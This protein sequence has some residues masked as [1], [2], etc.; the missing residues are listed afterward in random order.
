MALKF[1]YKKG[2]N[3]RQTVDIMGIP[4]DSVT[5]QDAL[6]R[7]KTFLNTDSVHTIYTPNAEIMMDA[8]RDPYLKN[9]L[10]EADMII[11]D[12]AGVV[13]ASRILGT[14]LPSKV[15]GFDLLKNTLGLRLN[16][17]TRFY[18][19]GGAPGVAEEAAINILGKYQ[20]VEIAGYR[21]GYF[22]AEEEAKIIE[23]INASNADVLAVALGAPKQE[24]WI[25]A[26]KDK[27]K[28]KICIGVGGSFDVFAGKVQLAPEFFRKNNLEWLY[29]LYKE[30]RRYKRMLKLPQFVLLTIAVRLGIKKVK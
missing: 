12:G 5:M 7:V 10:C 1:T 13:L 11:P 3:M 2:E 8:L 23:D 30:P 14:P 18:F 29:R 16:K 15:P 21:N 27:L 4:V 26:N 24:K 28:V 22:T 6:D 20:R 19:F 17:K 25:H 9:I